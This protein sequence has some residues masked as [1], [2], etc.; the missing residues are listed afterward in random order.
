MCQF[1]TRY[2]SMLMAF[3][4]FDLS[5]DGQ[6]MRVDFRRVL[7]EFGFPLTAVGLM[8]VLNK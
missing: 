3:K 1:E 8:D 4:L 2:Q 6:V 7:A 5:H